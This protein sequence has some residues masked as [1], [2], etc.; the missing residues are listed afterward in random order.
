MVSGS[1]GIT[2]NSDFMQPKDANDPSHVA[3]AERA[4][5]FN[6]GWFT[7]P[8]FGT[9][10]YPEVM[11]TYIAQ[12]SR[13][14]GLSPRLPVFTESEKTKLKGMQYKSYIYKD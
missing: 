2:L 8:I 9:G 10:D 14:A 13:R 5:Q 4:Q 3:A 11:K 1:V 7:S 6:L 12:K